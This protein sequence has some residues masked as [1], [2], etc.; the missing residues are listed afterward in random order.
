MSALDDLKNGV[1]NIDATAPSTVNTTKKNTVT[2]DD[3]IASKPKTIVT[4]N[5]DVSVGKV[6]PRETVNINQINPEENKQVENVTD[7]ANNIAKQI[8]DGPDSAFTKYLEN[9]KKEFAEW[10]ANR[11]EEAELEGTEEVDDIDDEDLENSEES[12][13]LDDLNETTEYNPEDYATVDVDDEIFDES[14]DAA[15]DSVTVSDSAEELTE[16]VSVSATVDETEEDNSAP[17]IDLDVEEGE[18]NIGSLEEDEDEESDEVHNSNTVEIDDDELLKNL[19]DMATEKLKPAAKKL[20]ISSFTVVKKPVTNVAPFFKDQKAKVAKWVLP[21]QNGT[22]FMKEF[23]GSELEKLREYSENS[24]SVDSLNR[25]YH[26]IYDHIVSPKPAT[27]EKWLKTTPYKDVDHYFFAVYIAS[28]NGANFL[29]I[30]CPNQKCKN[31]YLTDDIKIMD[32]VKFENKEAKV[33]FSDL[34]HS[35]QPI[36]SNGK[37]VFVTEVIPINNNIAI[38]FRDPSIYNLFEIAALDS[39]TMEK[40]SSIM[41]YIPYIDEVYV[42]DAENNALIPVGFKKYENNSTKTFKSKLAKYSKIFN[43]L[44]IDEF[45]IIKAYATDIININ[46]GMY[47]VYPA[48]ECPK[49]GAESAEV[50]TTAEELVFTRY[51]LGALINTSLN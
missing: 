18:D 44:T 6:Q 39:T 23:S 9:E 7:A 14:T 49:C 1:V 35:E 40:Y 50:R 34:Y 22:V 4:P 19:K 41:D 26:M 13:V 37:G 27:F 28:F 5:R 2:L 38:G 31:T 29:P 24:R 33:K 8:L 21:S 3:M 20:D 25:R 17:D 36:I 43:T 48:T 11:Q 46:H 10:T 32:M 42:I 16:S 12:L 47:Y 45:A 15:F 51:Q 30:D